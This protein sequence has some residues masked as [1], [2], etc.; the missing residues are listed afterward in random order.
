MFWYGSV[1]AVSR[2]HML[3]VG[4]NGTSELLTPHALFV[5]GGLVKPAQ[6]QAHA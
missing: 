2:P 6:A 3:F 1:P 5:L 4:K